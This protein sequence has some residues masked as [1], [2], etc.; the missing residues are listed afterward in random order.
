MRLAV[1]REPLDT[2]DRVRAL[3]QAY[4]GL[5]AAV[6]VGVVAEPPTLVVAASADAGVDAGRL[7]K[8]GLDAGGGRGGGHARL[9]QGRLTEARGIDVA[10]EA[11][12]KAVEA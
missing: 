1:L 12:R 7:L 4:G 5:A 8:A 10:L 6:F 2:L 11:I 3:A 9:A